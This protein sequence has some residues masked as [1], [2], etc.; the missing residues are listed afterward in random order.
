M[1][2][3]SV[4]LSEYLTCSS[5]MKVVRLPFFPFLATNT[6]QKL[7][8]NSQW[9]YYL[10]VKMK[11]VFCSEQDSI[12]VCEVALLVSCRYFCL[13]SHHCDF[14]ICCFKKIFSAFF[15]NCWKNEQKIKHWFKYCCLVKACEESTL[16]Y[17]PSYYVS[18]SI[19]L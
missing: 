14:F 18:L 5:F 11:K 12:P 17:S 19:F 6:Y 10:K 13:V 2:K 15:S 1:N 3:V 9:F 7:H 16:D 4:W 8:G